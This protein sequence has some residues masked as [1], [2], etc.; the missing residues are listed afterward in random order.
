MTFF[1]EFSGVFGSRMSRKA[2]VMG[3]QAP[4]RE[5][6][7]A[8]TQIDLIEGRPVSRSER[9]KWDADVWMQGFQT[10]SGHERSI[11]RRFQVIF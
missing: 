5:Q 8:T 4:R 1:P 9:E 7:K 3:W 11:S 2:S 6:R 10:V